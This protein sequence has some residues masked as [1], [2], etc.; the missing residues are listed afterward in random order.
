MSGT[1]A[2]PVAEDSA[3]RIRYGN[4]QAA[5]ECIRKGERACAGFGGRGRFVP[6]VF[7]SPSALRAWCA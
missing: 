6:F 7:N 5:Q 1:R 3:Y 4:G 2:V